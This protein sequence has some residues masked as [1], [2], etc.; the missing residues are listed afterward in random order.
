VESTLI[1]RSLY[2]STLEEA[3]AGFLLEQ[4]AQTEAQGQGRRADRAAQLLLEACRM[5]LHRHTAELLD[6]SA[7]LVAEDGSFV[8]LVRAIELFLVLHV[9]REPL[10]A[11]Q[12][13]GVVELAGSAYAR[14]C[15]LLPGL[16]GIAE[17]EEK[18]VLDALNALQQAALTLGDDPD[19]RSL[20][21]D[22]LRELGSSPGCRA[23]L[24]GAAAGLLFGDGALDPCDLVA[25]FRG[26]LLTLRDGGHDGAAFLRG[27][28]H[29]ARSVLWLVP[30]VLKSLHEVLRA[31]EEDR[32]VSVLPELRLAF[33]D[34]TPREC[35]HVAR[36]VAEVVGE[37][38]LVTTMAPVELDGF[39]EHDLL[40][41]VA[42]NRQ[43][44]ELLR[45]DSLEDYGG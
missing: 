35:D 5:G 14:A 44:L 43:V 37:A 19:R 33:A 31:W 2:G 9:S 42:V 11:H 6:R 38:G 39:H 13:G 36:S 32:F 7:R 20:R 3:G 45:Q 34:L 28:L 17:S 4:F 29:T 40:R 22:R 16:A 10:E 23:V 24:R 8:S 1:E 21:H 18:D 26:H 15:Y 25:Q 12:L 41:G 27:L 30:D